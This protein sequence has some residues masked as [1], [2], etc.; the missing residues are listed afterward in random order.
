[1]EA[2]SDIK[3]N[4]V[5][6]F[7]LGSGGGGIE[8]WNPAT[9]YT[10]GTY[11]NYGNVLYKCVSDHTSNVFTSDIAYWTQI[12]PAAGISSSNAIA[13]AIAL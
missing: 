10:A 8:D 9:P 2:L 6:A 12:G 5:S 7:T 1:M 11:I 13:L 4:N 3:K